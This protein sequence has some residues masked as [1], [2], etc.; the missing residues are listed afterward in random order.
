MNTKIQK[1]IAYNEKVLAHYDGSKTLSESEL[2]DCFVL[3]SKMLQEVS[4]IEL[5]I[6]QDIS[7]KQISIKGLQGLNKKFRDLLFDKQDTDANNML[8]QYKLSNGYIDFK[9]E[10][11]KLRL[12][13]AQLTAELEL[14][15][16]KEQKQ[17]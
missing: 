14:I 6:S 15:K 1:L 2:L 8:I 3:T 5:N 7:N 9:R 17:F 12:E 11:N 10:N 4:R 13:N 16:E